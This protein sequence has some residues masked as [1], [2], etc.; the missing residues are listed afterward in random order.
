MQFAKK[1]NQFIQT[2]NIQDLKVWTSQ[3]KRTIQTAEALSVPYEQWK[4]LNEIDAVSSAPLVTNGLYSVSLGAEL[5][6]VINGFRVC[7]R[8]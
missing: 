1:L 8:R 3:M 4:V 2:Q 6:F 5:T 7:A